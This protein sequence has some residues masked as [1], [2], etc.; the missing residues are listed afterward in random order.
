ME[1]WDEK[2]NTKVGVSIIRKEEWGGIPDSLEVSQ[3][4]FFESGNK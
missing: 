1:N 2:S 3:K 4:D